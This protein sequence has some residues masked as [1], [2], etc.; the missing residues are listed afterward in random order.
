[1]ARKGQPYVPSMGDAAVRA[2]TRRDWKGWF[3][4]LD[5]AGAAKLEHGAIAALLQQTHGITSW[6]SQMV[7]VEYERARGLRERHETAK[8]YSVAISKTL[9]I[10][11]DTLFEAT[12]NKAVR[13]R[14]FPGPFEPSSKTKNKYVRGPWKRK[15]RLAIGFY[16]RGNAKAQISLQVS[17]L[18][19][20]K[21]VERERAAWKAALVRLEAHL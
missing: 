12:A 15:S 5:D 1:M 4:L 6:W 20:Q 2:K 9:N 14:W 3:A 18:A 16:R 7:T 19:G 11:L 21:D 8:G 13:K 17:G 10:S